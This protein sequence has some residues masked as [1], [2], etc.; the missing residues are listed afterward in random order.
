MLKKILFFFII[1]LIISLTACSFPRVEPP[2][3]K[4]PPNPLSQEE[5]EQNQRTPAPTQ[6][7]DMTDDLPK[8]DEEAVEENINAYD[9]SD[10]HDI[11]RQ[12]ESL[13]MTQI[14]TAIDQTE[15]TQQT[16][17]NSDT[18]TGDVVMVYE[19]QLPEKITYGVKYEK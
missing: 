2:D 12:A 15:I 10:D 6:Q 17:G 3:T 9:I 14:N 5:G 8:S 16:E 4:L 11:T 7:A 13:L 1:L 18:P 19:K